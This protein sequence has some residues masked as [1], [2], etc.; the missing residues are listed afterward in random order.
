[1]RRLPSNVDET[2]YKCLKEDFTELGDL[3]ACSNDEED[4]EDDGVADVDVYDGEFICFFFAL[5][6][7]PCV[8]LRTSL[9]PRSPKFQA[10]LGVP[11]NLRAKVL[12]LQSR[13]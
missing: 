13:S 1:M 7:V 10:Y 9:R 2:F 5:L 4:V 12:P 3:Y 8:V 6:C 11:S